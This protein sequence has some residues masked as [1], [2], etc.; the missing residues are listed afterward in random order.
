VPHPLVDSSRAK[1]IE[2]LSVSRSAVFLHGAR[3]E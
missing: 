3:C 2:Y 1:E